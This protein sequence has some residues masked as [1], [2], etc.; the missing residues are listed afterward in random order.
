[1]RVVRLTNI[2]YVS[3]NKVKNKGDLVISLFATISF[4]YS[5]KKVNLIVTLITET[6]MDRTSDFFET[7]VV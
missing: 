5:L 3:F 4:I 7:G 1:M 6:I 2:L